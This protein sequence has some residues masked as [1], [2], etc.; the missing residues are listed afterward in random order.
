MRTFENKPKGVRWGRIK[1]IK[2]VRKVPG[3]SFQGLPNRLKHL[4]SWR[5]MHTLPGGPGAH[6]PVRMFGTRHGTRPSSN[7]RLSGKASKLSYIRR[8]TG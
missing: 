7:L 2:H 5:R 8:K 4:A 1:E 3:K 6:M